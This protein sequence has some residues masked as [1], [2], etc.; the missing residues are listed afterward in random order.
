MY[1][2]IIL[3]EDTQNVSGCTKSLN[4]VI[5]KSTTW[6]EVYV[7]AYHVTKLPPVNMSGIKTLII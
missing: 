6:S 1:E 5:Y 7:G 2:I 3:E 4:F